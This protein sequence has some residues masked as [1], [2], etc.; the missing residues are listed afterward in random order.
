MAVFTF[1]YLLAYWQQ[2]DIT[3]ILRCRVSY[4]PIESIES[5]AANTDIVQIMAEP[6]IVPI[7]VTA[8]R[9]VVTADAHDR[10]EVS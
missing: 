5:I 6:T 3:L 9:E 7:S 8:G 1:K 10:N 2:S 4:S